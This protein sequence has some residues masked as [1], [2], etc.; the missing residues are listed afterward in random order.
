MELYFVTGNPDKLKEAQAILKEHTVKQIKLDLPELQGTPEEVTSEKARI[1]FEQ[2]RKPVFVD[3][4]GLAFNALNGMPGIYI[5]HFLSAV[6]PEGV[7]KMLDGFDDKTGYSF[8]SIGF[9]DGKKT[10]VFMGK[11]EGEIVAPSSKGFGFK[12]GWDTI[13]KAKGMSNTFASIP[14]EEKNKVSQR[15]KAFEQFHAFLQ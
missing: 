1:A 3:D 6:G 11:C 12:K 10:E 15:K 4:T 8:T 9:C 13:F 5:K 2:T 7:Y 14:L